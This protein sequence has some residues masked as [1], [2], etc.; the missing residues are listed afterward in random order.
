M[1]KSLL[2]FTS[3][4]IALLFGCAQAAETSDTSIWNDFKLG[5]YSSAGFNV[6]PGGRVDGALDEIS[7]ILSWENNSSFRFFS[8]LELERPITF[9]KGHSAE[10]DF[11]FDL[12]RLY[13][14][15]NLSEKANLR[16]G[17]FLNPVGRWNTLHAAP[18][19][20]TAS[21]PLATSRL[22]PMYNNGLMFYGAVPL[23]NNALEYNLYI[24]ALKDQHEDKGEI[25]FRDTKGARF[26]WLGKFNIGLSL[27]E[28]REKLPNNAEFHLLGLDFLVHQNGW[29]FSG[30]AFQRYTN[31]YGDGGNGAY[32]Q[33]VAPLGHQWFAIARAESFKRPAEGSS[34]RWLLGTAWR[35]TPHKVLKIEYVDGDEERLGS[36]RGLLASFAILF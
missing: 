14:D 17:R 35:M 4:A 7:L 33:A 31:Q 15:Y 3:V 8:E 25:V 1:R 30:E 32:L 2:F 29:E 23:T 21:R 10:K 36:P 34:E 13:V 12:E 24:E 11:Y 26:A 19:V 18:L 16:A 28:F 27:L 9:N 22:F 6:H 20:W 5:G